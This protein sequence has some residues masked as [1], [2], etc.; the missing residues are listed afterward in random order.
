MILRRFLLVALLIARVSIKAKK[1]L[2]L[3][4]LSYCCFKSS[5]TEI[6]K[7]TFLRDS[8][9]YYCQ[10]KRHDFS[11]LS[12]I[13]HSKTYANCDQ[14]NVL[15]MQSIN[16]SINTK[17]KE[18]KARACS[19]TFQLRIELCGWI[20]LLYASECSCETDFLFYKFRIHCF[21]IWQILS[22]M[23][24]LLK[25]KTLRTLVQSY[26]RSLT[27]LHTLKQALYEEKP[28]MFSVQSWNYVGSKRKWL[29]WYLVAV[30]QSGQLCN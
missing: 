19:C 16:Q 14:H 23:H 12:I 6:S 18:K 11:H 22:K 5:V 24:F 26:I 17:E 8:E 13:E 2:Y 7:S 30:S 25:S 4:P 20:R 1:T 28:E 9:R 10:R 3:L 27:L 15:R 21:W 29:K